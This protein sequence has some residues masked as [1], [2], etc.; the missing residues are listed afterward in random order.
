MNS[1]SL[2]NRATAQG[3]LKLRL[4]GLSLERAGEA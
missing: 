3:C 4:G 2:S 1:L